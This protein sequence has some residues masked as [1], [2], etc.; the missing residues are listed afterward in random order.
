LPLLTFAAKKPRIFA[1]E[2]RKHPLAAATAAVAAAAGIPAPAAGIPAPAAGKCL[3]I[4]GPVSLALPEGARA[5]PPC[6]T[7]PVSPT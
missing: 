6:C 4:E 7:G 5:P 1:E 2:C 3:A